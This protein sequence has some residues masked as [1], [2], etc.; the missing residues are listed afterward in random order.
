M[1][2][3]TDVPERRQAP[4]GWRAA[5]ASVEAMLSTTGGAL[6][7]VM[8]LRGLYL[9]R[10]GADS[11]GMNGNFLLE[12]KAMR[13]GYPAE[14]TGEPLASALLFVLRNAGA[15]MA[16]AMGV[17]YLFGHTLLA[18]G[19][20]AFARATLAATVR[21]RAV[22]ALAVGVL[23]IFATDTGYRNISCTLAAGLLATAGALLVLK[24]TVKRG[25][26][27]VLALWVVA[28]L[29]AAGA[30][31]SRIEAGLGV[32]LIALALIIRGRRLGTGRWGATAPIAGLVAASLF[33]RHWD[34]G[35]TKRG[36][37]AVYRFYSG[38]V[39]GPLLFR[40]VLRLRNPGWTGHEYQRYLAATRV[41]GS[42]EDN[43]GDLL[44]AFVSHPG[45][46]VA[47]FVIKPLDLII[48]VLF[49]DAF[50]PLALVALWLAARRA[51]RLGVR[52]FF[53][54]WG[55]ALV[56]FG[57]PALV[58]LA[59][60]DQSHYILTLSPLILLFALWGIEPALA[61]Q[62]AAR[63]NG[64]LWV[65]LAAGTLMVAFL[66][67]L[68]GRAMVATDAAAAW[69]EDRC[70]AGGCLVNAL[71]ET[72]DAAVWADLQ[73]GA[74]LPERSKRSEAFVTH[75]YPARYRAEVGFDGRVARAR[76]AGWHGPIYYVDVRALAEP[77]F[78]DDFQPEHRLEGPVD[79]SA[80]RPATTFRNGLD[81]IDIFQLPS[82]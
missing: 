62:S 76:A 80:A 43:D 77:T 3:R 53:Q 36:S 57:G 55:P 46:A 82:R 26:K 6:A 41:F 54:Q 11:C 71:P 37:V 35:F 47:W 40:G 68:G 49:P 58:L 75:R 73:A 38:L 65:T 14:I 74:P 63:V 30:A 22:A 13:F 17:L 72:F 29:C 78:N 19:F 5:V 39:Q 50:T 7:L 59:F 25:R 1:T 61:R 24:S 48:H 79:L 9:A 21:S 70:G 31:A 20:L 44:H 10:F 42:F 18:W 56:T 15:S 28:L 32:A 34:H 27:R 33:T 51:R 4:G 52:P 69:L 23:P 45:K 16:V 67:H 64:G 66:G 81:T 60:C 2:A 12:A 8:V